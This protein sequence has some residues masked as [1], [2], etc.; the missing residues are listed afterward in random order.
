MK[1]ILNRETISYLIFGVLTTVVNYI[2]FW[3]GLK[4]FGKQF[5]LLINVVCFIVAA[6]FAYVTNKLFVFESKSWRR[7]V[8]RKEIP[9]FF[10]ARIV[11][12][13]LEEAGLWISQDLLH[14]D[15]YQLFGGDGIM[16][17]KGVLSFVVVLLKYVFSKLV[18]F[19]KGQAEPDSASDPARSR[20][21]DEKIG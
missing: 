10:S 7:E 18:I 14:A 3:L 6:S 5:T 12:F 19:K 21:S 1:K 20:K 2:V 4:L 13:L 8:I 11:S 9:A 15:R 17:A 16:I